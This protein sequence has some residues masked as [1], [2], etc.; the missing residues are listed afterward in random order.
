LNLKFRCENP[1]VS[2]V[3]SGPEMGPGAMYC[4]Q[5]CGFLLFIAHSSPRDEAL[6]VKED[7]MGLAKFRACLDQN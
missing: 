4:Y 1:D 7:F 2:S 3:D 5:S 6:V